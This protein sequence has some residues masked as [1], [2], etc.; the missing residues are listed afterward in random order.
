MEMMDQQIVER[1]EMDG[2][3]GLSMFF[4]WSFLDQLEIETR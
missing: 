2:T 3:D 1:R 4:F